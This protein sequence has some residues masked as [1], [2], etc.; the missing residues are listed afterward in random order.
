MGTL[1]LQDIDLSEILTETAQS[2]G[3]KK[4]ETKGYHIEPNVPS[5]FITSPTNIEVHRKTDLSDAEVDEEYKRQFEALCKGYEDIFSSSSKYIGHTPLI[6]M[7]IDTG[8]SPPVCQ[9]PYNLPL[10]HAEWIKKELNILKEVGVIT[11]S[12][13]P[14]LVL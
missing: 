4:Y 1:I 6:Q 14:W 13:S 3:D 12:V 8:G 11:K 10:K 9:Q 2:S 5:L 7:D